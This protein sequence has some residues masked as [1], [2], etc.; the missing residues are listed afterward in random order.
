MKY[1]EGFFFESKW[2]VTKYRQ[3]LFK[4][5]KVYFRHLAEYVY[6]SVKR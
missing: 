4:Y 1:P 2:F 6:Y 5:P 3:I